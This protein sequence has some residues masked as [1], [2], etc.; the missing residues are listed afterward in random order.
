MTATQVSTA[1]LPQRPPLARPR[2]G[3]APGGHPATARRVASR[4]NDPSDGSGG[5]FAGRWGVSRDGADPA[6]RAC[7]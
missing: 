6:A 3:R 2:R 5:A 7:R 4:A 1:T